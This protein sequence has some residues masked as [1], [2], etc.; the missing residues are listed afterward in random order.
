MLIIG[1][2]LLALAA[3][4]VST[5][6]WIRE[7]DLGRGYFQTNALVILGLL[8]IVVGLVATGVIMP[9]PADSPSSA[10]LDGSGT[11]PRTL[12][13]YVGF[14]F[15]LLAYAGIWSRKWF[16]GRLAAGGALVT[17]SLA[18]WLIDL[19]LRF[20]YVL[21]IL[22]RVSLLLSALV[23]GWSMVTMLLGH[24]YL[25]APMLDFRH[26]RRFSWIL[27]V[28][29]VLRALASLL[30]MFLASRL[31]DPQ[32]WWA[33]TSGGGWAMFLWIR[34][35]WGLLGALLLSGMALH[36][37]RQGSNQS[38]TGILYVVIISV[39]IGEATALFLLAMT[40]VPV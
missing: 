21:P 37:A 1:V 27:T 29:L 9:W 26:L 4:V 36:C 14:A 6:F 31:P 20:S 2:F 22:G 24:W 3:G 34:V 32:S 25:V 38:A 10:Q 40:G 11:I 39:W 7:E 19:P 33:L 5:S 18:L 12:L 8:A 13:L 17:L 16:L 23:L 28:L 30:A 35:L 15:S